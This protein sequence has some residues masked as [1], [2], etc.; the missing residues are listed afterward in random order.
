MMKM[1][2]FVCVSYESMATGGRKASRGRARASFRM[3]ERKL[4]AYII[5]R[6]TAAAVLLYIPVSSSP[7][8]LP[9]ATHA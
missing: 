4:C 7:V 3:P 8:V 6:R 1:S 9:V 2:L 5:Q